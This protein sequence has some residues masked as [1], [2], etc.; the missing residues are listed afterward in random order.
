MEQ[1]VEDLEAL[2][3]LQIE[4]RQ[5]LY[6]EV[7]FLLKSM[8]EIKRLISRVTDRLLKIP[9]RIARTHICKSLREI[10]EDDKSMI[11]RILTT[12]F[13]RSYILATKLTFAIENNTPLSDEYFEAQIVLPPPV[14]MLQ[15]LITIA[16]LSEIEQFNHEKN[17]LLSST[18]LAEQKMAAFNCQKQLP[19]TPTIKK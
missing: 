19:R 7:E 4:L 1:E 2:K 12:K 11:L 15:N 5:R 6:S 16:F 18:N 3:V 8:T 17:V 10:N 9:S 14:V 13:D